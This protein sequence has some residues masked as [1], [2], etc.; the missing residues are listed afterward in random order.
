ME[1][2]K[3]NPYLFLSLETVLY[4]ILTGADLD[5]R[6]EGDSTPHFD[7]NIL[8]KYN[9]LFSKG[10]F[11]PLKTPPPVDQPMIIMNINGPVF[12][13]YN[14]QGGPKVY[15]VVLIMQVSMLQLL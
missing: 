6:Q 15:F 12:N 3:L 8:S 11:E 2:L 4:S 9:F 5:F 1:I 14:T 13:A 10:G 7:K